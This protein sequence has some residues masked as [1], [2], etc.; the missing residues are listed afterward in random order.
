M[1]GRASA[2]RRRR[3]AAFL[4]PEPCRWPGCEQLA[5]RARWGCAPHYFRLPPDIR[6]GLWHSARAELAANGKLGQAWAAC[7]AAA[8][9]WIAEL[10]AK[11]AGPP[12][13]RWT[14]QMEL[15]L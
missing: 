1:V 5:T 4:K 13:R 15:D 2:R 8:A 10:L 3:R 14:P 7:A 9:T 11:Q 12:R 6:R